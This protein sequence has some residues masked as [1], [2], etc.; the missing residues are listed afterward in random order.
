MNTVQAAAFS[1]VGAWS[2]GP[3][4]LGGSREYGSA[5]MYD[6]GKILYA[7]GNRTTNTAETIDLNAGSP[8]WQWTGPMAF[9]RRHLNL[10]M[11]P[12]GDVLATGGVGGTTFN[13][14]AILAADSGTQTFQVGANVTSND[15][16]DVVTTNMTTDAAVTTVAGTAVPSPTMAILM[17]KGLSGK[18][19]RAAGGC[20][21][22]SSPRPW[23]EKGRG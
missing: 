6:D 18:F 3:N 17:A 21:I 15:R 22:S 10:T 23:E 12:T 7:G 2:G 1:S 8:Q 13:G 16:I 4:R 5:V 11:L 19:R 14:R 20:E 9:A